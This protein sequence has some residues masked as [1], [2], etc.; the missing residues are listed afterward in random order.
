MALLSRSQQEE[1]FDPGEVVDGLLEICANLFGSVQGVDNEY[2]QGGGSCGR[3]IFSL[4][5]RNLSAQEKVD[6]AHYIELVVWGTHGRKYLAHGADVL[7]HNFLMDFF[8]TE[9]TPVRTL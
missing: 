8:L 3:R 6:G 7:L 4:V 2:M 9:S 1:E 5:G